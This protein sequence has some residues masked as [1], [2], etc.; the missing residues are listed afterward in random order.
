MRNERDESIDRE[1]GPL[2]SN[3]IRPNV[4][5]PLPFPVDHLEVDQALGAVIRLRI[6]RHDEPAERLVDEHQ[7]TFQVRVA[8]RVIG[9]EVDAGSDTKA[10]RLDGGFGARFRER[11]RGFLCQ[12]RQYGRVTFSSNQPSRRHNPP[13]L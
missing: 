13:S 3:A 4:G 1:T 2:L 8:R 12:M 11:G 5:I 6:G 10:I 9:R 7:H